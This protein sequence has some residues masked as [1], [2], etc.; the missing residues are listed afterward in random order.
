MMQNPV[1]FLSA[2]LSQWRSP[3]NLPHVSVVEW[4]WEIT[5]GKAGYRIPVGAR[6]SAPVQIGPGAHP[7]SYTRGTGTFH[8]VAAGACVDHP[9]PT[10]T[11]V[12]GTVQVY[13]YSPTGPSWHAIGWILLIPLPKYYQ[14]FVR[15]RCLIKNTELYTTNTVVLTA[16]DY[17]VLMFVVPYILVTY[18]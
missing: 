8:G 10:R 7:A 12:E 6:F 9:S 11:E 2:C 13:I 4:S 15:T 16:T 1:H 14:Y 3:F 18:V 5:K 17:L